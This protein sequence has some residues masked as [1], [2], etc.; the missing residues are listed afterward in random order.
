MAQ[1]VTITN[2]LTGQPAQVDQLDHTAQE[3]DDAIARALPGGE[4]DITLQQ[5]TV[6]TDA[7]EYSATATYA[8]GDYCT[9]DGKLYRCTTAITE[10][11]AWTEAH[12]TETTVGAELTAI[13][14]AL[15][16]KAEFILLWENA[17][18]TSDFSAQTISVNTDGCLGIIV[19]FVGR[20]TNFGSYTGSDIVNMTI[21]TSKMTFWQNSA[22]VCY[23]GFS[24][25][26]ISEIS[27]IDAMEMSEY[28]NSSARTK[29]NWDA[30][31]YRIY[32]IKV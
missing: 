14:T 32:G 16:K 9:H 29:I 25:D 24:W 12:W 3:I 1:I 31:P 8:M 18:P 22:L 2:P 4:I 13:Y 26:S 23:R 6:V 17:S 5:I 15:Q 19:S 27:F 10:A 30:I 11:E 7:A 28:G 20:S 21:G